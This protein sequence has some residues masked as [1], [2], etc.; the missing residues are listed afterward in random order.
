VI[1]GS[2]ALVHIVDDDELIRASVS[3]LFSNH[4]YSTE[5]YTGGAEFF[6]DCKLKRGCIFLDLR[7]PQMSGYEVLEELARRGNMLP[8]VML[9][10]CGDLPAVVQAMKLGAMDFVEKSSSEAELLGAAGRA[11]ASAGAGASRRGVT[12]AA[13]ARL[14]R[15]S[16]R[17]K[18]IL[19]GL[20][21]G[22]SNK[23]I[24]RRL[25]L[26]PRTV[27]MH[28]TRMKRELGV[29][30]LSEAVQFAIDAGMIPA[31]EVEKYETSVAG[32]LYQS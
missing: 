23:G 14:D 8:V 17:Q 13:A 11:L 31:P 28:R 24:A 10:A 16:P 21:D 15:L 6:R 2:F 25:G 12:L 30:S 1:S 20:L 29:A 4:G 22:L 9:S 32:G 18:D 3:Y 5:I 7:M 26:S 19:Q 27:E